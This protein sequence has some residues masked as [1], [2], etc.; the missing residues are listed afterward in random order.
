M[1]A[2]PR[3]RSDAMAAPAS[4]YARRLSAGLGD[5]LVGPAQD[6]R[7]GTGPNGH[8]G[9]LV[10]GRAVLAGDQQGAAV[11]DQTHC[12]VGVLGQ[13]ELDEAQVAV[14]LVAADHDR[15]EVTL[16]VD[17]QPQAVTP[18]QRLAVASASAARGPDPPS[19]PRP[20]EDA[21]CVEGR[22]GARAVADGV[23][24]ADCSRRSRTS[25]TAG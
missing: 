25:G 10:D 16:V 18:D 22:R 21:R 15:V 24:D 13:R 20:A 17:G 23:G 1:S 5:R 3:E 14:A 19:G 2:P 9:A 4:S 7:V 8:L 11:V 12:V 6:A